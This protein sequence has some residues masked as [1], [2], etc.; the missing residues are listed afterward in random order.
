MI[1]LFHG[2]LLSIVLLIAAASLAASVV[3]SSSKIRFYSFL[4]FEGTVGMYCTFLFSLSWS[5]IEG[6]HIVPYQTQ[7]WGTLD[8]PW[9]PKSV[10]PR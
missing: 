6:A 8:L 5:R 7:F 2:E 9:F 1:I 3:T 10:E 4:M